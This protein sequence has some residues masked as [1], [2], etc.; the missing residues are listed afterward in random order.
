MCLV[1]SHCPPRQSGHEHF[2]KDNYKLA[3]SYTTLEKAHSPVNVPQRNLAFMF[4]PPLHLKKST[5]SNCLCKVN[6]EG[7]GT[8]YQT[9]D[10]CNEYVIGDKITFLA[11]TER[12]ILHIEHKS[13]TVCNN[14]A[15]YQIMNKNS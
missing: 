8:T 15:L 1:V 4:Q 3:G 12:A 11:N 2:G 9:G 6:R 5:H 13:G 7:K 10:E 14:S